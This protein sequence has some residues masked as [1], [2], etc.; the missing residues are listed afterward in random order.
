MESH[1]LRVKL[2]SGG[3]MAAR[4]L[5]PDQILDRWEALFIDVLR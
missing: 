1:E 3:R 4:E 5:L 2:G